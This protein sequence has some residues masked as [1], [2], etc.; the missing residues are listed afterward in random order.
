M[1]WHQL[2]VW[3]KQKQNRQDWGEPRVALNNILQVAEGRQERIIQIKRKQEW[4]HAG[5]VIWQE[6]DFN[7]RQFLIGDQA[8]DA[9]DIKAYIQQLIDVEQSELE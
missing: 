4:V 6:S 2:F 9:E 5:F 3:L 1:E 7:R 8:I